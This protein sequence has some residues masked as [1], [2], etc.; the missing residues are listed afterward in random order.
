MRLQVHYQNLDNSPWMNQFIERRVGRLNKYLSS[1]ANIQINVK[2][3]KHQ[4]VTSLAIHNNQDY[5]FS[6]QG[7]NLYE[8]LSLAVDKALRVLG[9]KKRRIK[10]KI[11][12][13]FISLK[14][15]G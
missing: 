3:E 10:D 2:Q 9:E 1:S 4:Y 12:K 8:A 5:A 14:I 11:N 15:I 7:E 13:K 6:A